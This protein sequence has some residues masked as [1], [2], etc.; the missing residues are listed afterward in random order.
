MNG[1][2]MAFA[3]AIAALGGAPAAASAQRPVYLPTLYWETGLIDTPTAWVSPLGGDLSFAGTRL[4]FDS[5]GSTGA[6]PGYNGSLAASLWGRAEAGVSFFTSD[7]KAA[8]FAKTLLWDQQDGEFRTGAAHWLPS[9]A[10]GVRNAGPT[11]GVDRFARPGTS[12]TGTSPTV[13]A[14]ATRTMV[15]APPAPGRTLPRAQLGLSLGAGN[16][17][18]RENGG[19]G[20][21]YARH[22]TGGVFG[23]A[24]LDVAVGRFSTVSLLAEHNA[25]DLNVGAALELRGVRLGLALT[26][27]GAGAPL[28]ELPGS[29]AYRKVALTVGWQTN[30][31]ALF[32][33][34]RMRQ[35]ITATERAQ[36]EL[37]DAIAAGTAR[38]EQ[39][40]R[41]LRE[42]TGRTAAERDTQKAELERLLQEELAALRR[43]QERLKAGGKPPGGAP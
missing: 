34:D 9:I 22:A 18:F 10:V 26:E 11:Q 17:L 19:L 42:L 41:Q 7:L 36:A 33:G 12:I 1:R 8:L 37:R 28:A 14:V 16:G 23:G 2:V 31:R 29:V 30:A 5:T 20:S 21:A 4:A 39:L 3:L 38:V 27:L 35:A 15:L 13:Y 25:W 32:R 40:E 24:K 43:L 6:R